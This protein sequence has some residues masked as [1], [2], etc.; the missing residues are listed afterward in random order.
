M[1]LS[2]SQCHAATTS[3][4]FHIL[5]PL[6]VPLESLPTLILAAT[7]L[8]SIPTSPPI[9]ETFQVNG[10]LMVCGLLCLVS[11]TQ[12]HV[13]KVCPCCFLSLWLNNNIPVYRY[14]TLKWPTHQLKSL[15]MDIFIFL[16]HI[17]RS[18][19]AG[20]YGNSVFNS[21]RSHQRPTISYSCIR[22]VMSP[23]PP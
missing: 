22:T 15:G 9:L 7:A 14:I 18:S 17:P 19:I 12:H 13:F 8:L 1:I 16:G 6:S 23:H 21:L 3:I 10:V 2:S 5:C 20:P 11:L 4:W